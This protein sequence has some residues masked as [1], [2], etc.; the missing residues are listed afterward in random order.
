MLT[1]FAGG[2]IRETF[3]PSAELGK[4]PDIEVRDVQ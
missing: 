2:G 1:S 3:V 4:D